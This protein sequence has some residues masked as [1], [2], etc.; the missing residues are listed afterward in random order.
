MIAARGTEF[1]DADYPRSGAAF[2]PREFPPDC[3][4]SEE[5]PHGDTGEEQRAACRFPSVIAVAAHRRRGLR[6]GISAGAECRAL[7]AFCLDRLFLTAT[8][9]LQA[10][11]R[12]SPVSLT[13]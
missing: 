10:H 1:P 8:S 4:G 6:N 12:V 13:D 3:T 7:R 11:M 5:F 2:G 9:R